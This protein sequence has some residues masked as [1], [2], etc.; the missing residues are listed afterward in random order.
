MATTRANSKTRFLHR[1]LR[2]N[3]GVLAILSLILTPLTTTSPIHNRN[4]GPSHVLHPEPRRLAHPRIVRHPVPL[5]P[6]AQRRHR[7]ITRRTRPT[8]EPPPPHAAAGEC[9]RGQ[10]RR[11]H[12]R[13]PG[14]VQALPPPRRPAGPAS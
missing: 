13:R 10:P 3:D 11:R 9:R 14:L 7:R 1:L 12:R 5:P 2:G 6:A 8:G 4:G